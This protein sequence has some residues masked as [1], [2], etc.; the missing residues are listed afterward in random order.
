MDR[1]FDDPEGWERGWWVFAGVCAAFCAI[2][3]AAIA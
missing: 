2:A 3:F 1:K